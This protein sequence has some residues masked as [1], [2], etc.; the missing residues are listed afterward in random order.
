[1][2]VY[3][4]HTDADVKIM[5]EKIGLKNL[6]A[7]FTDVPA[8]IKAK[9]LNMDK[10][11]SQFEALDTIKALGE[12]NVKFKTVLRGAG[13]YDHYI[14]SLVPALV[15]RAEFVTAY[16]PYQPEISQGILQS[17]FE[18]QTLMCNL[19]GMDASN[20]SLY[21]GTSA[22]AE[23]VTMCCDKKK[24]VMVLGAVNPQNIE[25]VKTYAHASG[26]EVVEIPAKKGL[27]D[28]KAAI[29][30]LDNSYAA[31]IAQCPNYFGLIEDM[32]AI[33]EVAHSVGAK[34]IYVFTPFAAALLQNTI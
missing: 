33:A 25:T 19:T 29:K 26:V 23:A 24:K 16:T 20:A 9:A 15:N 11:I 14:P 18:Y 34:M 1:M 4:P 6:D 7:L 10:G 30:M 5:L 32:T 3:T 13:A 2:A 17:I 27:V 12:E 31:V 28:L 8:K 22:T 21:D